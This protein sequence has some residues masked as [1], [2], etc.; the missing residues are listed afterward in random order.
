MIFVKSGNYVLFKASGTVYRLREGKE[1]LHKVSL[2]FS[3]CLWCEI[4]SEVY[5]PGDSDG[6]KRNEAHMLWLELQIMNRCNL[7]LNMSTFFLN[8]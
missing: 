5:T 8:Q 4:L 6:Q 3:K 1:K 7:S 2:T